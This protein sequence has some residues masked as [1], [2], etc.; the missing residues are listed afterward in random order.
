MLRLLYCDGD[1]G[2][3]IEVGEIKQIRVDLP[4]NAIARVVSL[5][6]T[7]GGAAPPVYVEARRRFAELLRTRERIV[8]AGDIEAAARAFEPLIRGVDVEAAS[9]IT[10]AGLGLV[11]RVAVVV[12]P[13]DFADPDADLER[14]QVEMQRYLEERTMI[15]HRL[16]VT[17][18]STGKG[19]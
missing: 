14:L 17:I 11:T 7:K 3:G 12:S 4:K 9:E 18:R 2:N 10:D 6:P 15:G 1:Y 16:L 13:D 8:T 5:T 19:R